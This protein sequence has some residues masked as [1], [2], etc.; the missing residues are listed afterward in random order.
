LHRGSTPPELVWLSRIALTRFDSL[1]S[2]ASIWRLA[3]ACGLA[4]SLNGC[5]SVRRLQKALPPVSAIHSSDF[6]QA[7]GSLLGAS[8]LPG[9]RIT[10]L[11]NGEE[12]FPA[13]LGA[14]RRAQRTITFE[15]YVFE[16][17]TTA[18]QFVEALA[19]R[20]RAGVEVKIL[21]DAVG[22]RGSAEYHSELRAAGAQVALFHPL[23]SADLWR[24]NNRTHR[25]LMVVDGRIGF[26]GGVGISDE[27]RG[28]ASRPGQWRELHYQVEGPAVAQMQAAFQ[29]N[30]CKTTSEVLLGPGYFPAAAAVGPARAGVFFSA[31][32]RGRYAVGLMYHLAIAGARK[33]L[34]VEN[35]YFVP[36]KALTDALCNAAR[37]G[38]K[39]QVIMPGPHIDFNIVRIASRKR[40]PRLREAGVELFEYRASM[41]HAKLLVA[42]DLFVSVGS[43]NFDPRSLAINDEANLIVL[44]RGFAREQARIFAADLRRSTPVRI[45]TRFHPRRLLELP[46]RWLQTP[47][48]PQL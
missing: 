25:K 24:M 37:R 9:N 22:A 31:P 1:L 12:I 34:R 45:S 20:A 18:R 5:V 38:V 39:V 23:W 36:D 44:D 14:I 26:I 28:R 47:F 6:A 48:E 35:A 19:E 42:D 10:T 29:A 4:I 17:G 8:F 11:S 32:Q 43:A 46:L 21:L 15:T 41:L 7:T 3:L 16:R 30:W 33:S 13:M 40:W 2:H 27:W